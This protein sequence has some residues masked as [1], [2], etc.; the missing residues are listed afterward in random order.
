MGTLRMIL[1]K[2]NE[3]P[4]IHSVWVKFRFVKKDARLQYLR[5]TAEYW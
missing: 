2:D 3:S 5:L 1:S 4:E